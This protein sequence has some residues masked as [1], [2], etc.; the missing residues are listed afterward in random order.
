M[1]ITDKMG[2]QAVFLDDDRRIDYLVDDLKESF[3][4]RTKAYYCLKSLMMELNE[5]PPE[6]PIFI[7]KN[8]GEISGIDAAKVLMATGRRF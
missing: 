8:L 1:L 7:D 5:L 3:D 4:V 6:I 2:L